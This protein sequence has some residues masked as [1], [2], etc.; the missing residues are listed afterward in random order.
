[1]KTNKELFEKSISDYIKQ[2]NNSVIVKKHKKRY[3]IYNPY[4]LC[5]TEFNPDRSFPIGSYERFLVETLINLNISSF[6]I[7]VNWTGR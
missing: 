3:R 1:M 4:Q 6:E 7:I 5:F 2:D